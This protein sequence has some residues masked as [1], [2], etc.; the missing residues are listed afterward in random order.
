MRHR[1]S[2]R[3]KFV[4]NGEI[5]YVTHK[6]LVSKQDE[7]ALTLALI[8]HRRLFGEFYRRMLPNYFFGMPIN[9]G[10][11]VCPFLITREIAQ[12]ATNPGDIDIVIIPYEEDELILE[13]TLT[14]E[15]K[16]V[17]AKFINQG[18]SP[19]EFGFSQAG[20]LLNLGFP[21]AAVAHLIV[22]DE[23]PQNHWRETKI[24]EIVGDDGQAEPRPDIIIDMMPSDLIRR[25]F[26]RL[27]KSAQDSRIGLASIYLGTHET[28]TANSYHENAIWFPSCRQ[29]EINLKTSHSLLYSLASYFD[30][31]PERFLDNPRYDE[32]PSA[33]R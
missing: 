21:Y 3:P 33:K 11:F 15:V 6:S 7:V 13:N 10:I 1:F 2:R 22:S 16:V 26:G 28:L 25:T 24:F 18:K 4:K 8:A 29:P 32:S 12:N 27:Q 17:R 23:S 31:N 5:A 30:N 9:S 19:N 20:H 14:V